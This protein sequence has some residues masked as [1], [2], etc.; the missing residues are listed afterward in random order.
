MKT[1]NFVNLFTVFLLLL[2]TSFF[3]SCSKDRIEATEEE[4]LSEY[5]SINNYYNTKKQDEQEFVIDTSGTAPIQGHE[6]TK[7]WVSKEKLMFANGDSVHWP[8][9]VKLIE[10]YPA[11]DMIYYQM[12]TIADGNLLTSHG[13]VKIT[14]FKDGE[15]LVLRPQC[16]WTVEMPNTSQESFMKTY[17]GELVSNITNWINTPAGNFTTTSYGYTAEMQQLGW[18]SCAKLPVFSG[19]NTTYNFTSSTDNLTNVSK[20]IYLPN[21]KSLMQLYSSTSGNLPVGENIKIIFIGIDSSNKLF[22]YFNETQVE[23]N[24]TIDLSLTEIT[25]ANLTAVLNSL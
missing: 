8:Y 10:L 7:I 2:S 5:E 12:P 14:A 6:G 18:I 1:S 3:N 13:E 19:N 16:T 9:T 24:T 20:F 4:E 25:D 11:K 21:Y 17:Y 22:Y 15:E 23:V